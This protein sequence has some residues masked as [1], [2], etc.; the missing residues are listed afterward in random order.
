MPSL[1]SVSSHPLVGTVKV[2]GD[3][4]ISHRSLMLSALAVGESN[5]TGL[6]EG[7]D[8]LATAAAMRAMGAKVDR[9]AE[10]QWRVSGVGVGGLMTPDDVIDM[11]NS[12]TS[13][14]LIM[15]LI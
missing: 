13:T 5:I 4:S 3:K 14:R 15:G 10:G 8:V 12:G 9:V 11:G 2:P 7:E 6:L 1:N